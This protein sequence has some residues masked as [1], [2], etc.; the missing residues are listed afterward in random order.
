MPLRLAD[1]RPPVPP[2]DLILRVAPGFDPEDVDANREAFDLYG[3]G[4]LEYFERALSVVGREFGEFDRLLDFGC[5]CGRFLRHFGSLASE[6]EINGTDID[7]EMIEWCRENI[8]FGRFEVAPHTPPLPYPEHHFD[9]VINHSVFSH[10][11]ERMQDLWLTELQRIT[12]PDALILLTVEGTS[13]W[14]RLESSFKYHG[15]DY[16]RWRAELESRGIVHIA[17]DQFVGSTHPDF[18]HSTFHAPWY[19]MEHWTRWFDLVA[20]VPDGS[21]SQDLILLRRRADGAPAPPTIGRVSA[22]GAAPAR[23]GPATPVQAHLAELERLARPLTAPRTALGRAKRRLLRF[24]LERQRQVNE[25][26]AV[27]LRALAPAAAERDQSVDRELAMTR[28]GLYEQAN[29]VSLLAKQL[30]E[31]IARARRGD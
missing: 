14:N 27:V 25:H 7:A 11:D 21:I 4:H 22:A 17:E 6:V 16:Q 31:E 30:R 3:L 29:R 24:E 26:L 28:A 19:V 13:S 1:D 5:G 18:Y 8:P 9:L 15:G 10:L 12:R 2:A 23:N 20:Y